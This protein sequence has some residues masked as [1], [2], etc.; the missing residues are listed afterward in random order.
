MHV[1]LSSG[2]GVYQF[3]L[4]PYFV[5]TSSDGSGVTAQMMELYELRNRTAIC[6]YDF[7]AYRNMRNVII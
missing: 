3:G 2:S 5:Y 6:I 1:H 7:G 4:N